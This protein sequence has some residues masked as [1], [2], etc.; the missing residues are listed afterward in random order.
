M[1]PIKRPR[2]GGVFLFC[3]ATIRPHTNVYSVFCAVNAVLYSPC[4]KTAHKAL[5]WLFLLFAVFCRCCV[6]VHPAI[7]HRLYHAGS[8]HSA[9]TPPANTKYHRHAGTLYRSAQPPIIIR[10][11]R[12]QT[13]PAAAGQLIPCADLWQVLHPAHLLRGQRLH[14][15]RVSPAAGGLAPGQRQGGR[16]GILHPAEQSSGRG[17]GGRR[18][19][20][21][22]C[23]R[24]SFRAFA[25]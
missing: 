1:S 6:A 23:R 21:G 17:R 24:I 9:A 18:G 13:M 16:S 3:P 22:G 2:F 14:L 7:S 5:Q 25:R 15:Y 12:G 20:I 8:Y 11:I 4:H 10:Y 19:T